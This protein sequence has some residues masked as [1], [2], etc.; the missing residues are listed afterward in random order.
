MRTLFSFFLFSI[1]L[2]SC[3]PEE[4]KLTAQQIIDKS[5][6]ISGVD[7]VP[8]SEVA[9][10]FRDYSY[11]AIRN[12]GQFSL[13][14]IKQQNDS[15]IIDILAND[16]Y[17]RLI[18]GKQATVIDS[19]AVKY[20]ESVNSVHYFSVLP[21]GLNDQAVIKKLL[22][23]VT[24]K[25]KAYYK[26]QITFQQEGGGVDYEDVFIYW[27]DKED[28]NIDY[29]AYTFHVNGGGKRFREVTKEQI[30]NGVRFV[31]Y[32]N[33]KPKNVD[34]ELSTLDVLFEKGE[35]IK[36]SEINLENIQLKLLNVE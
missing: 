13:Q 19:M 26:V 21:H 17:S 32:N 33:F 3:K 34:S 23:E 8:N 28:F 24:V 14:R 9:F 36:A 5:I 4:K 18:N 7:K 31:N 29:M 15:I 16:G 20:S 22:P 6:A 27:I 12:K 35:L 11:K 1:L 25:G 10:D 2:I 30:V